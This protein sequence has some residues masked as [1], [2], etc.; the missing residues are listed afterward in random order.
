M[1]L[2]GSSFLALTLLGRLLVKFA[3]AK[4]GEDTGLLAG[5]F[6]ATQGSVEILIFSNTNARHL[7][8]NPL[9]NKEF[10]KRPAETGAAILMILGAKGKIIGSPCAS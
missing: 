9:I 7:D 4:L 3:T 2:H 6:E 10:L 5:T 8:L 1:A